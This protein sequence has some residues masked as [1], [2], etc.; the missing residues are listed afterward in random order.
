MLPDIVFLGLIFVSFFPLIRLPTTSPPISEE[1]A[2]IIAKKICVFKLAFCA[3]A[4][5]IT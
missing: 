2:I 4:I 3:S 1:I 5:Q